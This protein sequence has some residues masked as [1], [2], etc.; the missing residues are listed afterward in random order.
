MTNPTV[1]GLVQKLEAKG[2]V[3]RAPHP[4]DR[5]S[6]VLVRTERVMAMKEE[7]LALADHLEQQ[8]TANLT[9]TEGEQ[10]V[11]LVRQIPLR[12]LLC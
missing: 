1:T 12:G 3:V 5:C 9:K 7:W 4:G 8:R 6:K 10:I 11:G 2:L